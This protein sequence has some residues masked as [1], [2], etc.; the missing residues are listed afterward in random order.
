MILHDVT[1]VAFLNVAVCVGQH[2]RTH[3][4]KVCACEMRFAIWSKEGRLFAISSCNRAV[5]AVD[6]TSTPNALWL[7]SL[8]EYGPLT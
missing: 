3:P 5:V 7:G 2:G 6:A 8:Y 1:E 4:L